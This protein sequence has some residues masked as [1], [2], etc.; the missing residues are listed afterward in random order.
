[1]FAPLKRKKERKAGLSCAETVALV[2]V[3]CK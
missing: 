3:V 1:M 2:T